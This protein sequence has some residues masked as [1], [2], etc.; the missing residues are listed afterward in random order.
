MMSEK[1]TFYFVRATEEGPELIEVNQKECPFTIVITQTFDDPPIYEIDYGNDKMEIFTTP[2]HAYERFKKETLGK[3][4]YHKAT[5][6]FLM[7][8]LKKLQEMKNATTQ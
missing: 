7:M 6:D 4:A 1:Q 2:H 5:A 3:H 8:N